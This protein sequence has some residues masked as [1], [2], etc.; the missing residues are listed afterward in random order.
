MKLKDKLSNPRTEQ[1][2]NNYDSFYSIIFN[3]IYS[4]VS[5]YHDAQDICQEVF[6]RYY[7]NLEVIENHRKWLF[8]CL[9]LVVFDYYK[10]KQRKDFDTDVIFEDIGMGYVNGFRD[11]RVMIKEIIDSLCDEYGDRDA[12]LF[13]LVAVYNYSFVQASRQLNLNYKQARYRYNVFAERVLGKLRDKGIHNIE[14]L[15]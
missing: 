6:I 2:I 9:R 14:D 1:F 4:K 11:T 3:S 10:M 15:L 5:N 7:N 8:G 13:E 12:S